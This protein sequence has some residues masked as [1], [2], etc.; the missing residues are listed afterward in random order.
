MPRL[1]VLQVPYFIDLL[2]RYLPHATPVPFNAVT[3]FLEGRGEALS[4][5][6]HTSGE[7]ALCRYPYWWTSRE[8][9][10]C[11]RCGFVRSLI[12]LKTL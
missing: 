12:G 6:H 11:F 2:R 4:R 10:F 1:G 3:E 5:Q 7:N 8:M 9:Q